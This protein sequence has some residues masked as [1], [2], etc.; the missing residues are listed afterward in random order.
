[1]VRSGRWARH[2]LLGL[3]L[4]PWG[5]PRDRYVSRVYEQ[6]A[7]WAWM[8]ERPDEADQKVGFVSAATLQ[9]PPGVWRPAAAGGGLAIH[10]AG[11]DVL[12]EARGAELKYERLIALD[13]QCGGGGA[14]GSAGVPWSS[15]SC[16]N[17]TIAWG[18]ELQRHVA[19]GMA[20]INAKRAQRQGR[21]EEGATDAPAVRT[22]VCEGAARCA[23][24]DG[25]QCR[26]I[27]GWNAAVV[28]PAS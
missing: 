23:A 10:P 3:Y 21:A 17:A 6:E 8:K 11:F 15:S 7:M 2:W 16:V 4:Y 25:P 12:D 5:L 20:V 1:M 27:S 13:E 28:K 19:G 22:V 18:D 9:A 14:D 24:D 26:P